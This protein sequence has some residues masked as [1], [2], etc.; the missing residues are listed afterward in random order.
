[1]KISVVLS[2]PVD[3]LTPQRLVLGPYSGGLALDHGRM[4]ARVNGEW[5]TLYW[6]SPVGNYCI[7]YTIMQE[8]G[9]HTSSLHAFKRG[10][11]LTEG[12]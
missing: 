5:I 6:R 10:E 11:L 7:M 2:D 3:S 8:D 12:I 9:S 4:V 1:M